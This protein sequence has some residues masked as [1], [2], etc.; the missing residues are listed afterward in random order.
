MFQTEKLKRTYAILIADDHEEMLQGLDSLL[1]QEE[2][3]EV[4]GLAR[5]GD[6]LVAK[7]AELSPDLCLVDY[8]MPGL[9]G[10][11]ASQFMLKKNEQLKIII[12]TM[13]NENSLRKRIKALGIKGYLLK[14]CENSELLK[15]IGLVLN[16]ETYFI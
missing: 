10:L 9:N 5:T 14:D 8:E 3:F 13:H 11:L 6:E 1:G 4:V 16:G 2:G 12:L 7:A 15:A